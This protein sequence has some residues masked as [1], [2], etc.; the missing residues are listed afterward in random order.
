V[1]IGG[2]APESHYNLIVITVAMCRSRGVQGLHATRATQKL[3][4]PTSYQIRR[5]KLEQVGLIGLII[6]TP[7]NATI[8]INKIA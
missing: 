1:I 5:I 6:S 4:G 7:R 8:N 2:F 3:G